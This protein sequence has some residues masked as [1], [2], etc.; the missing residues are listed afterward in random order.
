MTVIRI[1][2]KCNM[3]CEHCCFGCNKH[4]RGRHLSK[5]NFYKIV[6]SIDNLGDEILTITGGEPTIHPHFFSMLKYAVESDIYSIFIAT[7]GK[8]KDKAIKLY[9]YMRDVKELYGEEKLHVELSLDSYHEHIDPEVVR[10]YKSSKINSYSNIHE[11]IRTVSKILDQGSAKENNIAHEEG[12]ACND[13]CFE[14]DGNIKWCGCLDSPII[15]TIN[16]EL[17]EVFEEYY[18]VCNDC[19]YDRCFKNLCVLN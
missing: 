5:E 15:G 14:P 11:N 8:S 9:H 7:N 12:C 3:S 18:N 17:G 2:S 10:L 6:D 4:K 19:E 16:D 1:T 13:L